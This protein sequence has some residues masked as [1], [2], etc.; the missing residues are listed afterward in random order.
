LVIFLR[1][2]VTSAFVP[3]GPFEGFR[4]KDH[5]MSLAYGISISGCFMYLVSILEILDWD[6]EGGRLCRSSSWARYR[7]GLNNVYRKSQAYL[8][9]NPLLSPDS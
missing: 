1:P 7:P 6:V 3:L 4:F 2:Y 9:Y 5:T 8:V